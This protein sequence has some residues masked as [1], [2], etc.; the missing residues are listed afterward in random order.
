MERDPEM[1]NDYAN[2]Y[3]SLGVFMNVNKALLTFI[4]IGVAIIFLLVVIYACMHFSDVGFDFGYRIFTE[5]AIDEAPGT[6]IM[7]QV[8]DGMSAKE[9]GEMLEDK[10]LIRDANLFVL[11]LNLSAYAKKIKAGVYTLNTSQTA[12][13][14]IVIMSGNTIESTEGTETM[15]GTETNSGESEAQTTGEQ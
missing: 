2:H 13:E 12:K 6:D 11:Q 10:G 5:E 8:E 4:K 3:G 7:V 1:S 14:M 9:L 15:E